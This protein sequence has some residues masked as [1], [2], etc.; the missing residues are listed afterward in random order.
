MTAEGQAA[1][2]KFKKQVSD[3]QEKPEEAEELASRDALTGVRNRMCVE[4]MI[5]SRI[6]AGTAFCLT[7]LDIDGFKAVNDTHGHVVGDELLKQF[8]GDLRSQCRSTDVI[9]RWGGEATAQMERLRKWLCGNYIVRAGSGTR[10]LRLDFSFGVAEHLPQES[11]KSLMERA[12]AAMYQGKT[13]GR[14]SS[15]A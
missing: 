1:M 8:A 14:G 6:A 10:K 15:A 13:G 3:Y 11:L 7:M 5:E 9:G 2:A 4:A 12:D